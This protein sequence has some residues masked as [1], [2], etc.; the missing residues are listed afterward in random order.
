MVMR[1]ISLGFDLEPR[2]VKNGEKKPPKEM[3]LP[4]MMEYIGYCIFPGTSVFGPFLVYSEHVKFL[5]PSP[6]V[7]IML[8]H[9]GISLQ[10]LVSAGC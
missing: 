2:F 10:F 8:H 3:F 5:E 6:I 4:S 1:M 9:R 7:G